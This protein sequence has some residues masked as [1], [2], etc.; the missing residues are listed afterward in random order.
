MRIGGGWFIKS[1]SELETDIEIITVVRDFL[2][3]PLCRVC[4]FGFVVV[5]VE[6]GVSCPQQSANVAE[7]CPQRH[8]GTY[9]K[10]G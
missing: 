2:C 5:W 7:E 3:G 1:R 10:K 8:G 6:C 4:V 9:S